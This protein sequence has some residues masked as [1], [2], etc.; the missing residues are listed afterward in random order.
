MNNMETITTFFGWC[1][2]INSVALL[3]ATIAMSAFRGFIS[4]FHSKLMGV[5]EEEMTILYV[6]YLSNYK[7]AIIV[8]N[9]VPYIALRIMAG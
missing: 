2:V 4:R 9:L 1:L 6:Q 5:S 8:L 7:I 3:I